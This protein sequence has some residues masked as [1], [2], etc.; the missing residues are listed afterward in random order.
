MLQTLL[1]G[2]TG[3]VNV[4]V[5]EFQDEIVPGVG[6]REV[7]RENFIE[8]FVLALFRWCVQLKEILER[9]ELNLKEIR[10]RHRVPYGSEINSLIISV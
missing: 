3:R 10:T 2:V 5:Q 6:Y 1:N 9:F 7:L 8:S 4:I